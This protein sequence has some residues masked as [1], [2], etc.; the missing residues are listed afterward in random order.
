MDVRRFGD[1]LFDNDKAKAIKNLQEHTTAYYDAKSAYSGVPRVQLMRNDN[2]AFAD[3]RTL[4]LNGNNATRGIRGR[5]RDQGYQGNGRGHPRAARGWGRGQNR[6]SR[7]PS[8]GRGLPYNNNLTHQNKW[9]DESEHQEPN[10]SPHKPQRGGGR[11]RRPFGGGGRGRG[12][13]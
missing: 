13:H 10:P 3:A 12:Q 5:G 1:F 7:V 11:G 6:G 8:R 4:N 9:Q 2:W